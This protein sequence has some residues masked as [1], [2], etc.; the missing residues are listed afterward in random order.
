[1]GEELL[2]CPLV[3]GPSS[4]FF[5]IRR[6]ENVLLSYFGIDDIRTIG[7]GGIVSGLVTRYFG[8]CERAKWGVSATIIH[9]IR[10]MSSNSLLSIG[11]GR[12]RG[13]GCKISAHLQY[14]TIF[15]LCA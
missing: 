6:G 1:M 14:P 8:S 15:S 7:C 3:R 4:D 10:R 2:K 11:E 9:F 13:R 5:I 12:R